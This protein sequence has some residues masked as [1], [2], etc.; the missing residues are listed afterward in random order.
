MVFQGNLG[1]AEIA[2]GSFAIAGSLVII[3]TYFL[4]PNLRKLRYVELVLYI[5]INDLIASI[6]LAMGPVPNDSFACWFQALSTDICYVSSAFW[7]VVILYQ[8]Y[9]VVIKRGSVLKNML[10]I[11]LFCW[12]WPIVL[13]M[14]PLSTNT[15]NNPDDEST[16]CFVANRRDSPPWG[17]LFWVLFS[18]FFWIWLSIFVNV[19]QIVHIMLELRS[20]QVVSTAVIS[21]VRK[22]IFY[23]L[24]TF[25][26]WTLN[27]AANMYV[28]SS[29]TTFATMDS[30]WSTLASVGVLLALSQGLLNCIV[31]ISMNTIVR[32][33]WKELLYRM[34]ML[35][36]CCKRVKERTIVRQQSSDVESPVHKEVFEL[37]MSTH[38]S[39]RYYAILCRS[40][41]VFCPIQTFPDIPTTGLTVLAVHASPLLTS[42]GTPSHRT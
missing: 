33:H 7:T 26:C 34:Y 10:L 19:V 4:F 13:A 16:W 6:G 39:G 30:G 11:H 31:F 37:E 18:F 14:L 41:H 42:T 8:V 40:M 32:E 17:E 9:L 27:T 3:L 36:C 29:N 24:I 12:G 25:L 15:Y 22:L 2:M 28:F 1:N 5:A 38:D 23:P 35:L 20:M 21:T